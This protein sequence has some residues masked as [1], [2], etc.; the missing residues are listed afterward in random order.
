MPLHREPL[1]GNNFYSNVYIEFYLPKTYLTSFSLFPL[2]RKH[3]Q[4]DTDVDPV[5]SLMSQNALL[6]INDEDESS[7]SSSDE[8]FLNSD[9]DSPN[10]G[11]NKGVNRSRS[12][13]GPN[14]IPESRLP[15]NDTKK[16]NDSKGQICS[17]ILSRTPSSSSGGL[18]LFND[19][20]DSTII[21]FGNAIRSGSIENIT[22]II[23]NNG[24][25]IMS[26]CD[27]KIEVSFRLL[28]SSTSRSQFKFGCN[29]D[30]MWMSPFHLAIIA[31][32]SEIVQ[33][34]LES[35]VANDV[36]SSENEL[37]NILSHTT[38]VKFTNGTPK[39]NSYLEY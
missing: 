15:S 10:Q 38:C 19:K 18:L 23:E 27:I 3:N 25:T 1:N 16:K 33:V 31:R 26:K 30:L 6:T 9:D 11:V 37:K 4:R 22:D 34:M 39:G 24:T 32:Q 8:D 28:K 20:N 5:D 21:E 29:P 35:L 7:S 17:K 14:P 13:K 12:Y 36:L 2:F